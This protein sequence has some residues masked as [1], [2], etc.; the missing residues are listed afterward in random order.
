M[1]LTSYRRPK[2]CTIPKLGG[3]L[4]PCNVVFAPMEILDDDP[5]ESWWYDEKETKA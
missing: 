5:A 1:M 4:L 2:G 3:I